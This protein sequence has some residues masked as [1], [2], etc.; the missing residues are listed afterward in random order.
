[1]KKRF[2]DT[3]QYLSNKTTRRFTSLLLAMVV[4]LALIWAG[5]VLVRSPYS[6]MTWSFTSGKVN[7][8]D[9]QGP[10][11]DIIREGDH[12]QA[13]DGEPVYQARDFPGR[14]P[15]EG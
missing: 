1:M 7:S 8:V 11:A 9:P 2:K 4:P 12:I 10:A 5:G 6:G 14:K 3:F 15:G 13:I